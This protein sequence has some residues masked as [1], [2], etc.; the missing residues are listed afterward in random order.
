[1]VEWDAGRAAWA[2]A[3]LGVGAAAKLYPALFVPVLAATC[4][5]RRA[6]RRARALAVGFVAG[7]GVF[8]VPVYLAAPDALRHLVRF[9]RLR[10]PTRGSLWFFVFRDFDM[11]PWGGDVVGAAN[12]GAVCITVAVLVLLVVCFAQRQLDP[13]AAC[14]VA[15]IAF[16]LANKVYS[17][18]YDLW[19]VPFLVMI[20]VRTRI[21]VHF[22]A[23]SVLVFLC[24]AAAGH[25][26]P[27]P[28]SLQLTGAAVLYRAVVLLVAAVAI[29]RSPVE[30]APAAGSIPVAD[31]V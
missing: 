31:L 8:A 2:G 28:L 11:R 14:G 29:A 26:F 24:T 4:V 21:V 15:A 5:P 10:G 25:V 12:V 3:L 9:H 27:H 30:R 22:Y 19:I 13:I 18:Q 1:M 16:V 6:W 7:A 20:P 23:A 17:P